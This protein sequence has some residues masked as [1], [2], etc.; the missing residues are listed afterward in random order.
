[1][2]KNRSAY[3]SQYYMRNREKK[4]A[5]QQGYYQRHREQ[6]LAYQRKYYHIRVQREREKFFSND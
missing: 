6:A 5:Y 3:Y 2:M 1:M 4:L